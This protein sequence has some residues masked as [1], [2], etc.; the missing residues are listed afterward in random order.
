VKLLKMCGLLF[1]QLD[2]TPRI[3]AEMLRKLVRNILKEHMS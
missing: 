3:A 1:L 2:E